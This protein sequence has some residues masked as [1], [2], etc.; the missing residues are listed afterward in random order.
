[1]AADALLTAID[2]EERRSVPAPSKAKAS[3]Q[4]V[5]LPAS[6]PAK[7]ALL[8]A[9]AESKTRPADLARGMGLKPQEVTA[10]WICTTSRRSTPS[11]MPSRR[12]NFG[13]KAAA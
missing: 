11:P 10:S 1:M 9:M 8:N 7:V 6:T 12:W 3:E 5:G 2:F 13:F 4:L